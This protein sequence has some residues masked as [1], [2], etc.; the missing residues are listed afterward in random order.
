MVLG[1]E[2]RQQQPPSCD[3]MP[4]MRCLSNNTLLQSTD[5]NTAVI[6]AQLTVLH[7]PLTH[8]CDKMA[9]TC[10]EHLSQRHDISATECRLFTVMCIEI[11]WIHLLKNGSS[12]YRL[13]TGEVGYWP[14][15]ECSSVG[16]LNIFKK[17]I[18][19]WHYT[20]TT[21]ISLTTSK[22][23]QVSISSCL[24]SWFLSYYIHRFKIRS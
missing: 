4:C 15:I 5:K 14:F 21:C 7:K 9:N 16:P 6:W 24:W 1:V 8:T 18:I 22:S 23:N 13:L 20:S 3:L 17:W 11:F 19:L 12:G 10:Q 2:G